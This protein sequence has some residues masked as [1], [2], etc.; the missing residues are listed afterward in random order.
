MAE[1]EAEGGAKETGTSL[2]VVEKHKAVRGL[3]LFCREADKQ[4]GIEFELIIKAV[5][6]KAK[7]GDLAS[8]KLLL[9]LADRAGRA[10]EISDEEIESLATLLMREFHALQEQ[11]NE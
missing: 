8:I 9:Q 1:K 6:G 10:E 4:L 3:V 2:T 11:N 7:D 5:I